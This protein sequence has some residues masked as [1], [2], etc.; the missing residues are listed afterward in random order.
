MIMPTFEFDNS[1][2]VILPAGVPVSGG[3][4]GNGG[5]AAFVPNAYYKA[6]LCEKTAWGIGI[7]APYGLPP[8]TTNPG[9]A[10][11]TPSRLNW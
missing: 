9:S 3:D 4:G 1:G 2:S 8:S 6:D 5:V 10:A 11:T 7:T